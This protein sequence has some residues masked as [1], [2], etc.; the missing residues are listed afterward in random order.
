MR[1][2]TSSTPLRLVTAFCLTAALAFGAGIAGL[3][4]GKVP[5]KS[6]GPL[7]FGPNGL[8]FVGDSIGSAIVAIDTKDKRLK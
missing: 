8:L 1:K 7:A 4:T 5:L 6:A 3:A 2:V